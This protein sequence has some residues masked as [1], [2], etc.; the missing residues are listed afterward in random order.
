MRSVRGR[1][2]AF[3]LAL[4]L[5]TPGCDWVGSLTPFGV[6][7]RDYSNEGVNVNGGWVGKT[8]TGGAVTFQVGND[9]V[10]RVVFVHIT[11]GC[12]LTFTETATLA[13]IVNDIFTLQVDLEQGRFVVTGQFTSATACSGD[14][15]FQGLQAGLCPTVGTGTLKETKSF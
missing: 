6:G 7:T 4:A 15:H 1:A 13:P 10:S 3:F 11:P 12:T 5:G 8:A 9:T 2:V 14:Y